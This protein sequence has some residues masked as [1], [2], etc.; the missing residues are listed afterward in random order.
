M[1]DDQVLVAMIT[2]A[3]P[4]CDVRDEAEYDAF[5]SMDAAR[6]W[7]E[8]KLR[9]QVAQSGPGWDFRVDVARVDRADYYDTDVWGMAD[10]PVARAVWD[11]PAGA[12]V[13][14]NGPFDFTGYM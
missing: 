4:A 10:D 2:F 5:D 1:T 8:Q 14:Q 11:S 12:V 13:W 6:E 9:E 3:P 7:A